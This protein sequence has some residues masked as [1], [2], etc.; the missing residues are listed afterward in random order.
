MTLIAAL[1]TSERPTRCQ[2]AARAD[3]ERVGWRA[4]SGGIVEGAAAL[5]EREGGGGEQEAEQGAAREGE[6]IDQ[7]L[8]AE[9]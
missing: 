8:L 1:A 9:Q 7:Y 4:Q 3:G 5:E 2:C 6:G